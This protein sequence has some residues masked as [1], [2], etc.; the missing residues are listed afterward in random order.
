MQV[1][2]MR[3][4]V[5]NVDI[6]VGGFSVGTGCG[7]H[8]TDSAQYMFIFMRKKEVKSATKRNPAS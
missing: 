3:K 4:S 1:N 2:A 7:I 5:K 8:G 6:K